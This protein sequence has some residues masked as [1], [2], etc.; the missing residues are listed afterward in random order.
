M[1]GASFGE[2]GSFFLVITVRSIRSIDVKASL[3]A[4]VV[5]SRGSRSEFTVV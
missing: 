3:R 2:C 1:R 5:Q 4:A